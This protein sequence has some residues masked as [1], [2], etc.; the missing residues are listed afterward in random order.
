MA[1]VFRG[2]GT[3]RSGFGAENPGVRIKQPNISLPAG[4][5]INGFLMRWNGRVNTQPGSSGRF[6][7]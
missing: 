1:G 4:I 3:H 5:R 6:R 7:Q 2:Q